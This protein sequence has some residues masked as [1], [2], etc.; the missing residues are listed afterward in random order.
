M[1]TTTE[2]ADRLYAKMGQAKYD[3]LIQTIETEFQKMPEEPE[4]LE[5]LYYKFAFPQIRQYGNKVEIKKRFPIL[6]NNLQKVTS[7]SP[8]WLKIEA[9]LNR[10]P[11]FKDLPY[12]IR[13]EK[14]VSEGESRCL[15]GRVFHYSLW[16]NNQIYHWLPTAKAMYGPEETDKEIVN[17]WEPATA[18]GN[19]KVYFTMYE[20]EELQEFCD[21]WGKTVKYNLEASLT[22][23]FDPNEGGSGYHMVKSLVDHMGILEYN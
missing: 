6:D 4:M 13:Y 8:A 7:Q 19:G 12:D 22:G 16:M 21:N 5:K 9:E 3:E 2:I 15:W 20:P 18:F 1:L 11:G 10:Q 17:D 14:I 23:E